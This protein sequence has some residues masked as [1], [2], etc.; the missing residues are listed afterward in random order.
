MN[1]LDARL[2][3]HPC[4]QLDFP[5]RCGHFRDAAEAGC[6]H[7][8]VR[9]SQIGVIECVEEF[10]ARF[11]P[12]SFS[13]VEGAHQAQVHGL[14]ARAI[15]SV[16]SGVAEGV[17]GGRGNAT[18]LNQVAELRVPDP[19]TFSPVTLARMGF[20]PTTVPAFAVSPKTEMVMGNPDCT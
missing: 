17:G 19:K 4:A 13:Y 6:V 14:R 7:E 3:T 18:G 11:E 8:A 5:A 1:T 12:R 10:G 2:E 15:D 20:S 16:P 9:R